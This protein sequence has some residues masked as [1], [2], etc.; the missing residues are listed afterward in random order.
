M[1]SDAVVE[2]TLVDIVVL[3]PTRRDLVERA[4]RHDLVAA[5]MQSEG[6]KP[7]IGIAHLGQNL[8]PLLLRRTVHSALSNRSDRLLVECA[9]LA[10]RDCARSG[11]SISFVGQYSIVCLYNKD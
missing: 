3:D 6:R 1:I 8:C 7:I 9:T 4:A 11:P 10:S 2:H 5:T